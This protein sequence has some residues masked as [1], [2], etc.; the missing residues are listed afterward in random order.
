[1]NEYMKAAVEEA[2]KGIKNK[3]GGP[4]GS[5][6]V[7]NGKIVGRGHNQVVYKKDPTC[8]GEMQA[9]RDACK[10]LDTFD[11]TDCEL[12]TSGEPC[13]MC[14]AGCMWANVKKVYF[15]CTI[16]DNA[17][18]GFRDELFYKTLRIQPKEGFLEELDRKECQA[19]F[20]EYKKMDK[21]AY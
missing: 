14:L 17:D 10:T 6:V 15:G 12:Y 18:I 16:A 7:K 21:T 4:F 2:R 19:L 8:H 3:E 5:V 20:E 13:P 9:I 1:M 11:L